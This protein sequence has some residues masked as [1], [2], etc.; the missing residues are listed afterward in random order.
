M[1]LAIIV[2]LATVST[3]DIDE[4]DIESRIVGG[5]ASSRGKFPFYVFLEVTVSS[6][7]IRCG[8]S[9]ISKQW[10]VSAGHCLKGAKSAKVHLGSLKISDTK[11]VGRKIVD[12]DAKGI[13]LHPRYFQLFVLK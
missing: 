8:G 5:N 3:F 1:L 10:V 13:F 4:F 9:L 11:E 7:R 12:V 2:A 6:G